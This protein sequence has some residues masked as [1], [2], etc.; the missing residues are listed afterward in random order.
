MKSIGFYL[1]RL[2]G[3]GAERTL[4]RLAAG[5]AAEGWTP[6]L[7]VD[8]AQ[9][10]LLTEVHAAGLPF[11]SLDAPRTLA[12]LP[13]LTR[14]LR[15]QQPTALLSAITHNNLIAVWAGGWARVTTRIILS[16]HTQLSAQ[17]ATHRHWQY[18]VLPTLCARTYPHAAARV[19]VSEGV[20]A[21]L[22]TYAHLDRRSIT[23]IPNPVVTP[24]FPLRAAAPCSHPW[25][26]DG[27]GPVVVAAGRLEPVKDFATL[28]RAI[29]I[30]HQR[31]PVR[32]LI[33]GE[34]ASRGELLALRAQLGLTAAVDLPGFQPDPLPFF[35]RAAVVVVSSLYEGFGLT[36]V[37]AMACGAPVVSTDCPSGP[38]E[39]LAG[40][41]Y[42]R[43]TPVG[44]AAALSAALAQT[45]DHPLSADQ[46]RRRAQ[47]YTLAAITRCYLNLLEPE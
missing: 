11:S 3:G 7:V 13:R 22:A 6:H 29:A 35:A 32:L 31:R 27:G 21:D 16:E 15:Q 20:A 46:L 39:I 36:L 25:L 33:L 37:E 41:R 14:W 1:P 12:A 45:L 38:A 5:F 2:T 4:L 47:D 10:E 28:M 8:Q 23:V 26:N 19:A 30:L 42:G 40:G 24:D 17:A 34:G 9:G 44:D 18:R 43:L